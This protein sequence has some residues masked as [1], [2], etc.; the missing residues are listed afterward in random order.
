MTTTYSEPKEMLGYIV[1]KLIDQIVPL[2]MNIPYDRRSAFALRNTIEMLDR[3]LVSFRSDMFLVRDGKK[4]KYEEIIGEIRNT[5]IEQEQYVHAKDYGQYMTAIY[6]WSEL[7]ASCYPKLGLVPESR[8]IV[9]HE[10]IVEDSDALI[11]ETEGENQ[12]EN[13]EP[14]NGQPV[15]YEPTSDVP[16]IRAKNPLKM[17]ANQPVQR[18]PT[19]YKLL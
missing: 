8:E 4:V 14:T 5:I 1:V 10:N 17:E 18:K 11:D 7:I 12:N 9:T 3:Q 15:E 13:T 2:A 19:G 16:V 6:A